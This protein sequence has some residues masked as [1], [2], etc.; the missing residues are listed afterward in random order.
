VSQATTVAP[1]EE[2]LELDDELL[3]LDEELLELLELELLE[4][5]GI[6]LL[7]DELDDDPPVL[8]LVPHND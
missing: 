2:L 6:P 4:L 1:D 3:E 5:E 8:G 7:E